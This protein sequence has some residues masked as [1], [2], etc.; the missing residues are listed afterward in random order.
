MKKLLASG[1]YIFLTLIA[2][3]IPQTSQATVDEAKEY[4]KQRIFSLEIYMMDCEEEG[5]NHGLVMDYQYHNGYVHGSRDAYQ[6]IL[7]KIDQD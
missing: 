3:L 4:A 5:Y 2:T 1:I 6:N 7:N